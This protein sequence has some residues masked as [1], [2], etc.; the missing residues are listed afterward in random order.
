MRTAIRT[1]L[2]LGGLATLLLAAGFALDQPLATRQWPLTAYGLSKI[3]VAS[4][5]AAVAAPVLW[6]G[7][8]GELA[9]LRGGAINI[10]ASAGAGGA[11]MLWRAIAD[12]APR[13]LPLAVTSVAA[14]VVAVVLF[15]LARAIPFRDQR[16]MPN[17][18][19]VSF[20]LFALVLTTVGAL[21]VLRVR[22][23]FPWPLDGDSSVLYGWFFI[24]AASYFTYGVLRPLRA[25]AVGQLAGFL[26]YDLVLIVPFAQFWPTTAGQARLSLSIYIAVLVYSGV[27]AAWFLLRDRRPRLSP[28]ATAI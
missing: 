27:L 15:L 24:G 21:L 5:L 28:R 2:V 6:I 9:A 12:D 10:V 17:L 19:R 22:G 11:Y 8:S 3:F 7:L 18:V 4:M 14:A 26:A 13:L 25:N 16:P 1:I 20:A 23:V